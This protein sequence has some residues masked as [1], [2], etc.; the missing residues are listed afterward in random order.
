MKMS[1]NAKPDHTATPKPVESGS[2]NFDRH[3]DEHRRKGQA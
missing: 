3:R 1:A 2:R